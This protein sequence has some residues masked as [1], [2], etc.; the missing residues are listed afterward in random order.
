M[1]NSKQGPNPLA[2]RSRSPAARRPLA[3][4][5]GG[6]PIRVTNAAQLAEYP[7]LHLDHKNTR[8]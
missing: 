2:L 4:D 1:D 6:S 3:R 8:Q 5:F 7:V